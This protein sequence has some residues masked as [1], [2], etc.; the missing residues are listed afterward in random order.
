[1]YGGRYVRCLNFN[2]GRVFTYT[3][4][5]F[6]FQRWSGFYIHWAGLSI[7]GLVLALVGFTHTLG[8]FSSFDNGRVFTYADWIFDH[9]ALLNQNTHTKKNL[10]KT[11][12]K[13]NRAY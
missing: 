3:G 9:S 5:L 7:A 10:T 8:G 4:R 12:P 11:V 1:M 13:Q 2:A 6:G